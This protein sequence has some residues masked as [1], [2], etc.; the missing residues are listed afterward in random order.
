MIFASP[1]PHM[2]I[3]FQGGEPLLNFGI[4]KYIVKYALKRNR[5]YKRDLAFIVCTNLTLATPRIL[6]FFKKNRIGIST[7]LDGPCDLH[8]R[9]RPLQDNKLSYDKVKKNI[10]LA[11]EVL[12]PDSVAALMT[13]TK[14][15]LHRFLDIVDEYVAQ[16]FQYV[17]LRNLNPYG[18][19]RQ[20]AKTI[21]YGVDEFLARY[22][23]ALDYIIELNLKGTYFVESFAALLLQRILTPFATGFVDL[24][25]PS[26][27]GIEGAVY[28]YNGD[29]YVSDEGRMLAA[30]GD[31][32]FLLGNVN[33][34]THQD[35]FSGE[36]LRSL[37]SKSCLESMPVCADC[38]LQTY[39]GADPVRNYAE[40]GDV[41]CYGSAN[42]TCK[43]CKGILLHLLELIERND[44]D[45]NR[46]FWSWINRTSGPRRVR[47]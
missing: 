37:I 11:R 25:S 27:V 41:V 5:K 39:C 6:R 4:L 33:K 20:E 9:N 42:N 16:G 24:Q 40:H 46:V 31:S 32:R 8:N 7:S 3:E 45:I 29:V 22:K 36:S 30:M 14:F 2:K 10:G 26:G 21:G 1:S 35:M 34:N 18:G 47:N 19:A 17:F 23:E 13:T 28:D 15:S 38:A 43:K 12:G 44:P